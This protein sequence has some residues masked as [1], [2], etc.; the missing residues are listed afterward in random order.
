MFDEIILKKAEY[1]STLEIFRRLHSIEIK[2]NDDVKISDMTD[3]GDG[4]SS[5]FPL[6]SR[7]I[8]KMVGTREELR[9]DGHRYTSVVFDEHCGK[10]IIQS[11]V[12][13]DFVK[14]LPDLK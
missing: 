6:S 3:I 2:S 12:N 7:K 13:V 1:E 9:E 5:S 8:L 14:A 11:P 10:S 4:I